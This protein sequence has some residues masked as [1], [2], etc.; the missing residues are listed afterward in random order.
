[1]AIQFLGIGIGIGVEKGAKGNS[2]LQ[3]KV[4]EVKCKI[5]PKNFS[6]NLFFQESYIN[7]PLLVALPSKKLRERTKGTTRGRMERIGCSKLTLAI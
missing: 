6:F 3:E 1:M 7:Y 5:S 4:P 2:V